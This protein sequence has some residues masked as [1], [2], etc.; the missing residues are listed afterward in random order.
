MRPEPGASE[1][2]RLDA[3]AEAARD[4]DVGAFEQLVVAT[5]PQVHALVLR[6]VGDEHDAGDVVQETYLRAFRAIGGFRSQAAVTTWLYRIAAN[7][8]TSYLRRRRTHDVLGP[9]LPLADARAERDEEAAASKAD[10]R[11][12]LLAALDALPASLRSV[13]VLHDV[14]DL[15]HEAIANELGISRAASKVRLHRARRKL[16]DALFQRPEPSRREAAAISPIAQV[17]GSGPS[18]RS[19]GGARAL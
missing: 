19:A 1:R 15:A 18:R 16:R 5:S 2:A 7:C 11:A 8:S 10:E 14:Y 13:V 4:G 3:L 9:D 12:R 17:P 6:L